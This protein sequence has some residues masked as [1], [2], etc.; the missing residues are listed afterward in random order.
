V[1]RIGGDDDFGQR[2][3]EELHENNVDAPKRKTHNNSTTSTQEMIPKHGTLEYHKRRMLLSLRRQEAGWWTDLY[4]SLMLTTAKNK[5]QSTPR[6]VAV[7][8]TQVHESLAL[9]A[10]R[11]S[12]GSGLPCAKQEEVLKPPPVTL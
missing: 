9:D 7:E 11:S 1:A 10:T 4:A 5:I 12:S 6:Q 8:K 2:P 3:D